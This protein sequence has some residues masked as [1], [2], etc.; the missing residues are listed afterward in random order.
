MSVQTDISGLFTRENTDAEITYGVEE[1]EG[2][3]IRSLRRETSFKDDHRTEP[4][5][6]NDKELEMRLK[7]KSNRT[8]A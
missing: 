1:G 6:A 7:G 8:A 3:S 4:D 5:I 2:A